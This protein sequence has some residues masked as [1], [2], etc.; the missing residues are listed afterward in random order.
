MNYI[1]SHEYDASQTHQF[2]IVDG[3]TMYQHC[4]DGVPTMPKTEAIKT[5]SASLLIDE[6]MLAGLDAAK[7]VELAKLI[8]HTDPD[9][10]HTMAD[11]FK[12]Y[13]AACKNMG[14]LWTEADRLSI[15]QNCINFNPSKVRHVSFTVD[16]TVDFED[17]S[18][19]VIKDGFCNLPYIQTQKCRC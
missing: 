11:Q 5:T 4:L 14:R 8:S 12:V 10:D 9:S 16:H 13:F 3:V 7:K 19:V 18:L 17:G 2:S 15:A 1:I 6:I